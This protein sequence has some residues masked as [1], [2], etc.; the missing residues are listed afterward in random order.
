MPSKAYGV[1]QKNLEQVH[2]LNATYDSELCKN[3]G[4]GKRSLDHIT[5]AGLV[6]LCSSFEIYFEMVLKESCLILTHSIRDPINLPKEVKKTIS[7]QVKNE[8]NELSPIIFASNW[9]EY[10]LRMVT[11][12]VEGLNTPKVYNISNLLAKYLGL[13]EVIDKSTYPFLGIDDIIT[14]RGEVAHKLYATKY[15]KKSKLLEYEYTIKDAVKDMDMML[16]HKLNPIIG[17]TPWNNT[18]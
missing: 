14:E 1:F 17:K 4:K 13:K 12:E 2:R 15:L 6:F 3:P 7:K 5:R 8:N 9:K 11:A 16:Y 18:Y 10:Y